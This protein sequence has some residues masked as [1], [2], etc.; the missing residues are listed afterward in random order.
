MSP[1]EKCEV[2]AALV[3]L[4]PGAGGQAHAGPRGTAGA[5]RQPGRTPKPEAAFSTFSCCCE[6]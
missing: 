5:P 4:V 2:S 3:L 6:G 1:S